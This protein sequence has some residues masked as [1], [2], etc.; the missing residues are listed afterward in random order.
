MVGLQEIK[1]GKNEY[2]IHFGQATF[3]DFCD[4]RDVSESEMWGRLLGEGMKPGDWI[5]LIWCALF[6]GARRQSGVKGGDPNFTLT[7]YDVADLLT[8][9]EDGYKTAM[10]LMAKALPKP[11]EDEKKAEAV[12]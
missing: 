6:H 9:T 12:G 10:E 7:Q 4:Q 3:A 5:V 2:P 8:D 1:L 11:K